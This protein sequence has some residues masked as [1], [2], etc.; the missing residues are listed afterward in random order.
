MAHRREPRPDRARKGEQGFTLIELLVVITIISI[1]S[2]VVSVSVGGFITS[3]NEKVRQSQFAAVQTAVDTYAS[4]H[5]DASGDLKQATYP[6]F[7]TSL[8]VM[9]VT[10]TGATS[11]ENWYGADGRSLAITPAATT[12]QYSLVDMYGAGATD[13]VKQGFIS[14]GTVKTIGNTTT[15]GFKCLYVMSAGTV[16]GLTATGITETVAKTAVRNNLGK[17]LACRDTDPLSP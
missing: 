11:N 3:A 4:T 10:A 5:L 14:K 12:N 1:L 9:A 6:L 16:D 15:T 8:V 2:A 7:T 17:V 13:L